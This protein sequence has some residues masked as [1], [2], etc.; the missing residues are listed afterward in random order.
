MSTDPAF[1]PG[2]NSPFPNTRTSST[3]IHGKSVVAR[4]RAHVPTSTTVWPNLPER[5]FG[6]DRTLPAWLLHPWHLLQA[7]AQRKR[8]LADRLADLIQVADALDT[9]FTTH[10][11]NESGWFESQDARGLSIE[12]H[13]PRWVDELIGEATRLF[14]HQL[15]PELVA[16]GIYVRSVAQL[17]DWQREWLHQHFMARIYP[18]LTPLAVD[19]GRPFPYISS[20]SLNLLVE[21]QRTAKVSSDHSH[22]EGLRME[23]GRGAQVVDRNTLFARVKVPRSTP[24]LVALPTQPTSGFAPTV[25]VCSADLVR[26]FVQHLF[27]GMTVR[28]VYL[29]RLVRGEQCLPGVCAVGNARPRRQEDKPVVRLDVEQ[30]MGAAVL[31][32]LMEH[33][34]LPRYALAQHDRL[35]DWSCLPD[36]VARVE[37]GKD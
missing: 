8:P 4:E 7:A 18:L 27:P 6:V 11:L 13:I 15:R 3:Q 23:G 17:D 14:M 36:L 1:T 20:D 37:R 35:F 28:H 2:F 34:R 24:R 10:L 30:R 19:P 21:L 26:F 22:V 31:N 33:L 25:Y 9:L 16:E 32:W 12:E 29:F 5:C